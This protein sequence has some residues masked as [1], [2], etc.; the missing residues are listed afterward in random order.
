MFHYTIWRESIGKFI[1]FFRVCYIYLQEKYKQKDPMF[2]TLIFISHAKVNYVINFLIC[3]PWNVVLERK[4][5]FLY[6]GI[7]NKYI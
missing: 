7:V 6:I 4:T 3:R 1:N 2:L 5:F